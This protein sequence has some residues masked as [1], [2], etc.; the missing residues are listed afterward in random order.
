MPQ[1]Q[2]PL[3]L[4]EQIM[5]LALRDERGTVELGS[6]YSY[7]LGGALLA[8]LL[9]AGRISVAEGKRKLVDLE[10]D[11]PF[12]DPVIDEC[13]EKIATARRRAAVE[14]WLRRFSSLKK[15]HHRVAQRLCERGILRA[16]DKTILLIFHHMV[17]PEIDPQPERMLI[18]RLRKT[19][20]SDTTR[21]DP[22]TAIVISLANATDL[23]RIPFAKRELKKRKKRIEQLTDGNLIGQATERVVD[24]ARAAIATACIAAAVS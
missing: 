8:E 19:I 18:E 9:L 12:G 15:L 16:D 23:L 20:F 11:E 1:A 21:V 4:H 6:I 3:Y 17:Y 10:S 13:I 14:T 7:A 5:L 22:R 2:T 24:A